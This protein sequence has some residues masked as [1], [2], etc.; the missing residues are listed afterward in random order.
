VPGLPARAVPL[1]RVSDLAIGQPVAALGYTGGIGLQHSFGE[2]IDLH[3]FGSSLV[4]QS[5]S[6][7]S[8]GA[9]GGGLFDDAG[10]LVGILTFHLRGGASQYF[11]APVDWVQEMLAAG[12]GAYERVLPLN[13]QAVPYW[14]AMPGAQPRFLRAAALLLDD[15][16]PELESL[17][18]DWSRADPEDGEPWYL[19]GVAL[20]RLGRPDEARSALECALRLQPDRAVARS[21]LAEIVVAAASEQSGPCR[22]S[23]AR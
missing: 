22:T 19:L 2:V 18:A 9:S 6:W 12:D 17:A 20:R 1:G 16:W 23:A 8:S 15:R 11:A 7:F 13:V 5:N 4:I 14:Q 10:R 3:R 21:Q